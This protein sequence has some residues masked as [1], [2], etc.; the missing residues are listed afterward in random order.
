MTNVVTALG[1][2]KERSW[3]SR[4]KSHKIRPNN[5]F[6]G[7]EIM[8]KICSCMCSLLVTKFSNLSCFYLCFSC[9]QNV[10]ISPCLLFHSTTTLSLITTLVK[11]FWSLVMCGITVESWFHNELMGLEILDCAL[12]VCAC[13]YL[14]CRCCSDLA[15]THYT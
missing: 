12:S 3:W 11:S 2:Y 6:E 15:F 1:C 13:T 4:V 8:L 5:T 9:A 10:V 14:S 7:A